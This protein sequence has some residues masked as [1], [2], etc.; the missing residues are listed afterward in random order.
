MDAEIHHFRRQFFGLNKLSGSQKHQETDTDFFPLLR[1]AKVARH[2]CGLAH[3]TKVARQPAQR[4]ARKSS[5]GTKRLV[6]MAAPLAPGNT[7]ET[8]LWYQQRHVES[9]VG[10]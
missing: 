1:I 9:I 4:C 7:A 10:E 5:L 8:Y 3:I 2:G 6:K